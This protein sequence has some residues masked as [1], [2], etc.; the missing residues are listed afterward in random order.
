MPGPHS[1][2]PLR[3]RIWQSLSLG[4]F[5]LCFLCSLPIAEET[6]VAR[7]DDGRDLESAMQAAVREPGS[8]VLLLDKEGLAIAGNYV[9]GPG[10]VYSS[11]DDLILLVDREILP[12]R[13]INIIYLDAARYD[14]E[15]AVDFSQWQ[16]GG[17]YA[18]TRRRF[19]PEWIGD[20]DEYRSDGTD[21]MVVAVEKIGRTEFGGET[22]LHVDYKIE[23]SSNPPPEG[24]RRRYM[25]ALMLDLDADVASR[26][27]GVA[28]GNAIG[29][30]D[31][32][33]FYA[34]A[35]TG[36]RFANECL[37]AVREFPAYAT[38]AAQWRDT[39]DAYDAEMFP[40][41]GASYLLVHGLPS[42]TGEMDIADRCRNV[43]DQ[44]GLDKFIRTLGEQ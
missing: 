3:Q 31:Y 11:V 12:R 33:Y 9:I 20:F 35:L 13:W 8:Y 39:V 14:F 44:A 30:L 41:K 7:A 43:E 6:S 29:S 4:L 37:S 22:Y 32:A 42:F 16:A 38:A 34:L 28:T 26:V 21:E 19:I 1:P 25:P 15:P 2:Y 36:N 40:L 10:T 27:H 18:F 17:R 24:G 23:K 5:A